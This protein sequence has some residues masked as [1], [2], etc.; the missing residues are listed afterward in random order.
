MN[1]T[2]ELAR[3]VLYDEVWPLSDVFGRLFW[4]PY[5]LIRAEMNE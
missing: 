2:V 4:A 3:D 1:V 5:E